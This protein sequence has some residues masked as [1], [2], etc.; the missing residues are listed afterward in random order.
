MA[1]RADV[2]KVEEVKACID[3]TVQ[4]FGRLD[5]LF[6]NAGYQGAFK[7]VHE[8]PDEDFP[9]VLNINVTGVYYFL[10][11]ATLQMKSQEPKGG[12]I[13]N[14]ASQAGVDGPP[15]MAAYT[16][17]KAAV[18]GLTK[19]AAKDVAPHGVRV[20]SLSPAFVGYC[21]MWDRQCEL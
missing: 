2:C 8:Y 11:Y 18:I 3:A 13:L 9:R 5:C 20:N 16:A 19:T 12:A 17:S 1:Y 4:K 7:P 15:N 10:K 21:M 14:T 6:N